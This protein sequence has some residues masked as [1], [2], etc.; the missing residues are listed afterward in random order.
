MARAFVIDS[1]FFI[2]VS[3]TRAEGPIEELINWSRDSSATL[4]TSI[5]VLEEIRTVPTTA[6]RRP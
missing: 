4:H 2:S 5:R 6:R 3:R 1:N